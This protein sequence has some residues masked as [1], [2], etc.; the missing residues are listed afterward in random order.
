MKKSLH[1]L[2]LL[3]SFVSCGQSTDFA[4]VEKLLKQ[5]QSVKSNMAPAVLVVNELVRQLEQEKDVGQALK[6]IQVL[7]RVI[8]EGEGVGG[9]RTHGDCTD[10]SSA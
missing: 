6:R 10:I 7:R 2:L 5:H 1:I 3:I 8:A 4:A 9:I